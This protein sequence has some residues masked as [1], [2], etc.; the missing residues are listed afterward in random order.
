MPFTF[1][2]LSRSRLRTKVSI[3]VYDINTCME[4]SR[5]CVHGGTIYLIGDI[6]HAVFHRADTKIVKHINKHRSKWVSFLSLKIN[7][8]YSYM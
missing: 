6:V 2:L 5:P 8:Y 7:D 4:L 1:F 3:L